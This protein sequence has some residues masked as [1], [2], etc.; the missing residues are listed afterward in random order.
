MNWRKVNI[1]KHSLPLIIG[2]IVI[3]SISALVKSYKPI[4]VEEE[5]D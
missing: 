4:E 3:V 5:E 2:A 1:K